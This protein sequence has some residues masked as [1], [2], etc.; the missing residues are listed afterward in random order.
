MLYA[1]IL[2]FISSFTN[3]LENIIIQ[4]ERSENNVFTDKISCLSGQNNVFSFVSTFCLKMDSD[5]TRDT[6][7]HDVP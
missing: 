5:L 7:S 4:F 1:C 3:C 6:Y 2:C